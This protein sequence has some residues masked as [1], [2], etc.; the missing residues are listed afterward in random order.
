MLRGGG[1]C[2]EQKRF[3][4]KGDL[5]LWVPRGFAGNKQQK[6]EKTPPYVLTCSLCSTNNENNTLHSQDRDAVGQ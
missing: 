3:R 1:S 2:E 5:F 6:N 4:K